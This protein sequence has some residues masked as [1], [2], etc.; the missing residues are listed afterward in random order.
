MSETMIT[1][2]EMLI[3]KPAPQVF[4]AFIDPAVTTKF[5]FSRSSGKLAP[6]T[7]VRWE[8]GWY[9]AAATVR[10]KAIEPHERIL[11]EWGDPPRPVEWRFAA[12]A[13]GTTLVRIT[14]QG[15]EGTQ[16]EIVAQ[17][18]DS[19]GGFTIVLAGLKAWL[20]HRIALGLVPDQHPDAH[21]R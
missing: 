2:A 11:I 21:R 17:A 7:A 12:R 13:D 3:R 5:W 14:E 20:E 10:V 18:L 4:D 1:S 9:G 16:D 15:F 8:W 6:D 19:K